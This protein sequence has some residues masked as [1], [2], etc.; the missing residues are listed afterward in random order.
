[1]H[2]LVLDEFDEE[3]LSEKED[4]DESELELLEEYEED[5]MIEQV[6]DVLN[7]DKLE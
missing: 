2:E 7:E 6:D 3:E 5:D 1:M 4:D